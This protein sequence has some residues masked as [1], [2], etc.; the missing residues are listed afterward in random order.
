MSLK[1]VISGRGS[2]KM[3]ASVELSRSVELRQNKYLNNLVEQDHRFIKRL[4]RSG[5]G[6]HSFNTARR[7][8]KG[9]EAMNMLRKGQVIGVEKGDVLARTEFVSQ[10]FGVAV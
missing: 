5:M 7:T 4:T 1:L 8:L 3:K 6:F 2:D 10:I 9:F